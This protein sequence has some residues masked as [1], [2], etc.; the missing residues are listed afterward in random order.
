MRRCR[1]CALAAAAST[2]CC[3]RFSQGWNLVATL[4]PGLTSA[5]A[6]ATTWSRAAGVAS[7]RPSQ[8]TRARAAIAAAVAPRDPWE[9]AGQEAKEGDEKGEKKVMPRLKMDDSPIPEYLIDM[10]KES[11]DIDEGGKPVNDFFDPDEDDTF[12]TQRER[13]RLKEE[14]LYYNDVPFGDMLFEGKA[15]GENAQDTGSLMDTSINNAVF[16]YGFPVEFFLDMLCRWGVTLPINQDRRLGDMIDAEQ[17]AALCEALTGLDA[18]D[19]RDNYLDDSLEDLSFDLD[20]PLPDLFQACAAQK[21]N[22]PKGG[23]THITIDEYKLLLDT[24][25][26]GGETSRARKL[27][28][29]S[30]VTNRWTGQ[31]EANSRELNQEDIAR[32]IQKNNAGFGWREG[33]PILGDGEG[34]LPL[35]QAH[36]GGRIFGEEI[37]A[38]GYA[39]SQHPGG[40]EEGEDEDGDEGF[41]F[42]D[43]GA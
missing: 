39:D 19:V 24:V 28:D 41:F 26:E 18:A 20:I 9:A 17:A 34:E 33:P 11:G 15:G 6:R 29:E 4:N 14:E 25:V 8:H 36:I 21:I 30:R 5:A 42:D 27:F 16:E 38:S 12:G 32:E 43:F 31:K 1:P 23:D 7:A 3:L 35:E 13:D 22:L 10:L 37:F 40:W 2:C